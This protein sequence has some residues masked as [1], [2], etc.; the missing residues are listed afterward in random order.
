M[1]LDQIQGNWKQLKG[2]ARQQWGELTDDDMD[3]IAGN[4]EE[5]VGCVQERYGK[6]RE[7]AEREVRDWF[8]TL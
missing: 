6:S 7:D 8:Q 3:R 1:N 4:S 2:R 5:L